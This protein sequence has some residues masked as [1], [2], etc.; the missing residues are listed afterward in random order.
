MGKMKKGN[1]EKWVKCLTQQ[2]PQEKYWKDKWKIKNIRKVNDNERLNFLLF[3]Y[4]K[5]IFGS[6]T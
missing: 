3:K 2:Q 5:I 1:K 4:G 6:K